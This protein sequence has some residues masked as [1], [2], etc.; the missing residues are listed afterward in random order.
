MMM[1]MNYKF[2]HLIVYQQIRNVI[3]L[4]VLES[5]TVW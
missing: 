2:N 1:M 5:S 4:L 3:E